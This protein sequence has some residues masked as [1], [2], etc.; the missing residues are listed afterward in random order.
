MSLG[1]TRYFWNEPFATQTEKSNDSWGV[2]KQRKKRR[3]LVRLS[4]AIRFINARYLISEV[5]FAS[6]QFM[7]CNINRLLNPTGLEEKIKW[8]ATLNS[9]LFGGMPTALSA[10][11]APTGICWHEK[12]DLLRNSLR[13]R[14]VWR[15]K[16]HQRSAFCWASGDYV[17]AGN[18]C[19]IRI[20]S[21]HLAAMPDTSSCVR[22][23]RV[24][25]F[26]TCALNPLFAI[27]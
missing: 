20:L 22:P 14:H 5:H 12:I 21:S 25:N 1:C 26:Q 24:F 3:S 8:F 18:I 9:C 6:R 2:C 23:A 11:I 16:V 27:L 15:V 19:R 4:T 10:S 7:S 13:G 17:R